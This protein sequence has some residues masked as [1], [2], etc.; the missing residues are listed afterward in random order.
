MAAAHCLEQDPTVQASWRHQGGDARVRHLVDPALWPLCYGQTRILQDNDMIDRGNCLEY[1][2]LGYRL[3]KHDHFTVKINRYALRTSF[4]EHLISL[5]HQCL[6]TEVNISENGC[7]TLEGYINNIHPI[8]HAELYSTIEHCITAWLPAWDIIYRWY[9]EFGFQRLKSNN[10]KRYCKTSA[11][12]GG[13]CKAW[14]RPLDSSQARDAGGDDDD[15]G[16]F[17]PYTG[18]DI[19]YEKT[20]CGMLDERWFNETHPIISPDS[21]LDSDAD[22][23]IRD[24]HDRFRLQ[25][26]DI[27][28]SG[29]F[30]G[31]SRIQVIVEL[32]NIEL[33]PD[34]PLFNGGPWHTEAMLN[35]HVCATTLFFYD[36]ENVTQSR[37]S[38]R[39]IS[40][41]ASAPGLSMW[42]G[43]DWRAIGRTYEIGK[44]WYGWAQEIGSAS[45]AQGQVVMFPNILQH[46][47]EP[48]S[49]A[50]SNASGHR[51]IF[52]LHLVDPAI[53]IISTANVAP[54]P[55]GGTGGLKARRRTM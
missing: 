6:P 27:K 48:F 10:V 13:S 15:D 7:A 30:T 55:S 1:R 26:E 3:P 8:K 52:A 35:E 25:M 18:V 39:A 44:G 19:G 46:K 20:L 21:K 14:N 40:K 33:T 54:P 4:R 51:K 50:D 53:P 47:M 34:Q 42:P 32:I 2:G 12:C 5:N 49:L 43:E 17:H 37:L 16:G 29:Y 28:H 9:D 38:F 36:D 31:A 11:I 23:A 22:S 41:Q 24:T 45:V